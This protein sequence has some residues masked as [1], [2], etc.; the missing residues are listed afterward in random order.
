MGSHQAP[1]RGNGLTLRGMSSQDRLGS[2]LGEALGRLWNP[3]KW[4]FGPVAER[5]LT[6]VTGEQSPQEL[7]SPQGEETTG[8][9][10][11]TYF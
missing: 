3:N 7:I 6:S 1:S 11:F 9:C 10:L 4:E 2:G 5:S 8:H